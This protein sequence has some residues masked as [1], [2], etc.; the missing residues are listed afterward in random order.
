[1]VLSADPVACLLVFYGRRSEWPEI[2]RGRMLAW[3]RRP[4]LAVSFVKRFHQV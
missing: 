1:V 4:W 2:L 3:G